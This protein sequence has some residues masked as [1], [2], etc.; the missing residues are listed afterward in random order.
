M[1]DRYVSIL[2]HYADV[3][4]QLLWMRNFFGQVLL[5]QMMASEGDYR[6]ECLRQAVHS[7][8]TDALQEGHSIGEGECEVRSY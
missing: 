2:Q 5:N 3:F 6:L 1:R 4:R 8:V 7:R